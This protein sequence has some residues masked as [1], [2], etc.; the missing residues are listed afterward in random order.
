[1]ELP[2][3][4][5]AGGEMLNVCALGNCMGV[6]TDLAGILTFVVPDYEDFSITVSK[7]RLRDRE[8]GRWNGGKIVV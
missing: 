4:S 3:G 8:S 1:M 5:P 2:D 7:E 6:T